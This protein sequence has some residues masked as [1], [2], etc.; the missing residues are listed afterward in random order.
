VGRNKASRRNDGGRRRGGGGGDDVNEEDDYNDD[1]EVIG[2]GRLRQ[3]HESLPTSASDSSDRDNMTL[4]S[5][6][7][8]RNTESS[9]RDRDDAGSFAN[10][11]RIMERRNFC[12]MMRQK[13][14]WK[15][16]D[17]FFECII[18]IM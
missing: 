3:R 1:Y 16:C 18:N 7:L 14:K 9:C 5:S 4:S 8:S 11:V 17:K 2:D 12:K 10:T 13:L 15:W 6:S